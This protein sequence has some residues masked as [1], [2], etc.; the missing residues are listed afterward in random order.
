VQVDWLGVEEGEVAVEASV[1]LA[2]S[3]SVAAAVSSMGRVFA[4]VTAGSEVALSGAGE[5]LLPQA[6]KKKNPHR[7]NTKNRDLGWKCIG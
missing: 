1:A 2:V 6:V 4:A 3:I 7:I 5:A